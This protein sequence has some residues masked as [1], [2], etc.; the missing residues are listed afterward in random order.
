MSAAPRWRSAGQTDLACNPELG[1]V[2]L[3]DAALGTTLEALHAFLPELDPKARTWSEAPAVVLAARELVVHGRHLRTLIDNYRHELDRPFD[4][5][6][7]NDDI[8]F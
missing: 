4:E 5:N 7:A 8:D 3:L 1:A 6:G 2:V